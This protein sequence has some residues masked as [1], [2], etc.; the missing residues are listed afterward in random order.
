MIV[1]ANQGQ[2]REFKGVAFDLL[3][4]GHQSMVTKMRYASGNRVP[5]HSHPNE[6]SGY[7]IS[8]RYRLRFATFDEVLKPGDSYSIPANVIHSLEILE[9]GEVVDV[10]TPPR[11]DYLQPTQKKE[12]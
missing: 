8:G 2:P 3:A 9:P 5:E 4:V 6:Q 11:A 12:A 10:F 1:K 7:V